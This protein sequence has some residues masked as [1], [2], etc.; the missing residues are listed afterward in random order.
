MT[1]DCAQMK[2][3]D[4]VYEQILGWKFLFVV[5]FAYPLSSVHLSFVIYPIMARKILLVWVLAIF[6]SAYVWPKISE[7][8]PPS[9]I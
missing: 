5:F 6:E 8:M 2:L 3:I 9:L 4:M 1:C 7:N